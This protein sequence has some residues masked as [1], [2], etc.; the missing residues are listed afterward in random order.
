MKVI[1]SVLD[2]IIAFIT[3]NLY[4][5]SII[6]NLF[7]FDLDKKIIII[8]SKEKQKIKLLNIV[9]PNKIL[10]QQ[11]NN[12]NDTNNEQSRNIKINEDL[13]KN[14]LDENIFSS[15]TKEKDIKKKI[16]KINKSTKNENNEFNDQKSFN[17]KI[18]NTNDDKEINIEKEKEDE[19]RKI[20]RKIKRNKFYEYLCFLFIRKIKNIQNTLLDEGMNVITEKLDILNI[21]RKINRDD[22]I[23]IISK[24]DNIEMSEICKAKINKIMN[25]V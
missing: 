9:N 12:K 15:K 24:E 23:Q 17:I 6:N 20:I 11:N 21:F 7:E 3:K 18:I 8:K 22:R 1:L 2:I 19:K 16:I 13:H 5:K 4:E 10:N 25:N 14:K